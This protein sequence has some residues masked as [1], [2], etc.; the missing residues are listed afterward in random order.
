M[1]KRKANV[2]SKALLQITT[3][4]N[5]LDESGRRTWVINVKEILFGNGFGY[6]WLSQNIGDPNM[7]MRNFTGLT[8]CALQKHF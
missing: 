8:E 6:V 2:K 4:L 5:N 7:C 3:M 1:V